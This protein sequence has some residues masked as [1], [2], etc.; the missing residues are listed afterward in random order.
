MMNFN[1]TSGTSP[2]ASAFE[3]QC[4]YYATASL[5]ECGGGSR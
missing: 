4:H 1:E 2:T 5:D 3:T